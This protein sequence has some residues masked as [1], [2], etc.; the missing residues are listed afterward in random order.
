MQQFPNVTHIAAHDRNRA[1]G[2]GNDLVTPRM[3]KDMTHFQACTQY[4]PVIIGPKT[5]E[6]IPAHLW[7]F[8]YRTTIPISRTHEPGF[9]KKGV[10]W[11]RT[12][13]EALTAALLSEGGDEV[14]IIGGGV[15][16][17]LFKHAINRQV[18][19]KLDLEAEGADTWYPEIPGEW[20]DTKVEPYFDKKTG[21]SGELWWM[22]RTDERTP[23]IEIAEDLRDP[24]ILAEY[25]ARN[26]LGIPLAA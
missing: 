10:L 15:I 5:A 17:D 25:R 6:S 11:C 23:V 8:K 21:I 7:P 9:D 4:H 14:F 19:T 2:K 20:E 12:P 22:L 24:R 16:Y 18:L 26:A 13:L 3:P 1:I